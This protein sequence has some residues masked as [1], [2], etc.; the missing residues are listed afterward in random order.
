MNL[1]AGYT[2]FEVGNELLKC[3]EA[4]GPCEE[5]IISSFSIIWIVGDMCI[6]VAC[7]TLS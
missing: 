7:Q 1:M 6:H 3:I 5:N 4:M 2:E